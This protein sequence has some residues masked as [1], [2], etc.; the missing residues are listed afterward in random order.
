MLR[1]AALAV[2]MVPLFAGG[3][4]LELGSPAANADPKAKGA[5]LVTRFIG[6]QEPEKGVLEAVAI[7]IVNGQRQTLPLKVTALSQPGMY[8]LAR[9]WPAEGKWVVQLTGRHPGIQVPTSMLVRVSGDTFE[10][11]DAKYMMRLPSPG[12]VSALLD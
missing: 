4:Y 10:R 12:E 5:V 6:C 11:K 8:A 1:T 7:G 9:Q 2:A 3:F